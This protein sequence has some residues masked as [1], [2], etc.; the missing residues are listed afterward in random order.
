MRVHHR[1]LSRFAVLLMAAATVLFAQEFRGTLTGTITDPSGASIP[2]AHVRAANNATG[3]TYNSTT[4]SK[5][6]YYIPYV[7]PGTY[8]VTVSATGFKDHVQDTVVVQAGE[9]RGLNVQMQL[10]AQAQTVTVTSAPPLLQTANGSGGTV[11]NEHELAN[12]PLNGRQ[13]YMLLGTTPGSQFLQTQFGA[14]GYSGTRGWD[15]SNNYTLGGGVQG[16]QQF[17]LNGSNITLQNHGSQGEWIIAPNVDALQEVNVMTTTYNARYGR[18]GGG[19]VNMVMKSGTNQYHGDA[20]EY[21]ENGALNANNF[22]NNLNGIPRQ[23]VHQNQFGFTFGGPIK[24]NK[25][26]FFGSYEQYIE[27][28]PFTTVTSVPPAYM[29]PSGGNGVDFTPSG[30]T[31]YDPA[32]T[33]CTVPGGTLG[34]CPGGAYAR[35]EFPNDT[36]PADR[37]NPI[38]TAVMNL[39]P[40]PNT[41]SGGLQNNFTANVPDKYRYWQPMARVDYDT[42]DRTRW[43]SMF[44]YQHGTEF[45]NSSGF[46]SP[47]ENGNINQIRQPLTA[48]QDMTHTFSP[49][50]LADFKVAFT[51]F[52]EV[53]HGGDMTSKVT[54]E[55]IGL[56]MPKVPTTTLNLLPEFNSGQF[57][58]QVVGNSQSINV[59]NN[60][61]FYN[62]WT[63][64]LGNHTIHF[65]GQIGENQYGNPASVGHANGVFAF[66]SQFTQYD[67]LQRNTLSGINDGFIG[68]DMLL[69][70]PDSG[71]VD[72]NDTVFE[73]NPIYA[74]YV[75]DDWKATNHLTLNIGVR[76]DV[77]IGLRERYNRLN[78]GMCFTCVNPITSEAAYQ[79]NVAA[80]ASAYRAA[81]LDPAQLATVYGG[82][83][84]PGVNGNSKD[85]YDTDWTNIEPRFG[86]A[87]EINSKTVVRGGYGLFYAVGLEGGTSTGFSISSPYIESV[88]NDVTPTNYFASGNPYPTGVEVP[89]GN[90]LGML[91]AL[92]N[93]TSIDFPGRRIPRSQEFSLGFQRALPS[94]MVLSARFVGNYTDRL[95]VFVW[96]NGTMDYNTLQKGIADPN[97]FNQQVPNP[98]YGVPGIP[99]SSSCGSSKTVKQIT[100]L[101]PLSQ[102]CG[103]IGQY[104]DPL[105][106]QFYN[107]LEVKLNKRFSHGLSFQIAYTYSKT[108]QATGYQNGW[109]YQD[110]SL[111]YEI[112]SHDRTHVF[113]DT[114][115]WQ[116]PFGKGRSVL[117]NASGVLG[118]L[119]NGW[120][121]DWTISAETGFPVGM[122]TGHW[123]ACDHSYAPDGGPTL[124]HYLYNDYSSGNPLGCYT[125]IPQYGL[126]N[127]P[128]QI[129][130]VRQPSIVN[131]NI[132]LHKDFAITEGVRVQFRGEA[133]NAT[134]TVLFPGPDNN[135]GDGPP[136]QQANGT[137]TG[138]GTVNLFQ[139]N[140]PRIIQLSLKVLF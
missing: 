86:F 81:G 83:Q 8:T 100:L 101:L 29:R 10:G 65:G 109:P 111:K 13:V 6:S 124:S 55:S 94:Q 52:I 2:S 126:M 47:A 22:E 33:V 129:S 72:Y 127:L 96:D 40:L 14:S 99:P 51:R 135:P 92:G 54:P 122:N 37:I 68:A 17:T 85:A 43:Y 98:Y 117:P 102:Y 113:T 53:D 9:S 11:L 108:M 119:V 97:L 132:G 23:N 133:F 137:W 41:G 32:T 42:S 35:S 121:A 114:T 39:Y 138:F 104:N 116:L 73:G 110:P 46:P 64:S 57:Y 130:Q 87:Y 95:R 30:Y 88:N 93:G 84:F 67:P 49:T 1:V 28:I 139:Q 31:I 79:A 107:G 48:S 59:Y 76:Y 4:T 56:N 24:K 20:Y 45:R 25:I 134:N 118:A 60:F 18:T 89:P 140:F 3:Q 27:N 61:D 16:Y 123:Y 103:L 5:G 125:S 106:K 136:K 70:Y 63:K 91:T 69:G 62:D 112:G 19:T 21:F 15:T 78:R 77:Q 105:G 75:Q 12:I 90:S 36:I 26:F 38:G 82:F 131:L 58:P 74:L 44:S 128:N 120:A 80:N 66:G 7:L 115:E 50:L 71:S 34:N